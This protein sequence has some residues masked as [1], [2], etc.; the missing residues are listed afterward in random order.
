MVALAGVVHEELKHFTCELALLTMLVHGLLHGSFSQAVRKWHHA[1][2]VFAFEL[3]RPADE[4]GLII[5][6]CASR[7][8]V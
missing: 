7:R 3:A 1:P 5:E 6:G 4:A 8:Q 2:V